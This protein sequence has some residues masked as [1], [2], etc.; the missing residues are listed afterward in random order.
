M[1][2]DSQFNFIFDMDGL[3]I[4]S[5]PYWQAVEKQVFQQVGIDLTDEMCLE[6]VGLRLN[7]I[8]GHWYANS[9]GKTYRQKKSAREL[10]M[11]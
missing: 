1:N 2:I 5:E 4:D 11:V 9:L 3:L 10:L 7:D 6:T 8:V